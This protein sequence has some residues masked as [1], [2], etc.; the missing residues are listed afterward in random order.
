MEF[1]VCVLIKILLYTNHP[2]RFKIP[3]H[4][5]HQNPRNDIYPRIN[6]L[7]HHYPAHC[8]KDHVWDGKDE[9]GNR[10]GI[11]ENHR[12]QFHYNIKYTVK[13]YDLTYK[14]FKVSVWHAYFLKFSG[15]MRRFV[16]CS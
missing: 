12:D 14:G 13:K 4:A 2:F 16:A 7:P 9:I 8:G 10:P 5:Y 3:Y 11:L 1:T 6:I 15:A